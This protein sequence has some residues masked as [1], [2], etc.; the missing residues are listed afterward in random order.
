MLSIVLTI[1]LVLLN[2][3]VGDTRSGVI[4]PN[5]Q[6]IESITSSSIY[7][8]ESPAQ[9]YVPGPPLSAITLPIADDYQS[10]EFSCTFEDL[11]NITRAAMTVYSR[12]AEGELQRNFQPFFFPRRRDSF[13]TDIGGGNIT[14][15]LSSTQFH[16]IGNLDSFV[17]W[18]ICEA[19][20]DALTTVAVTD[21]AT[22]DVT[23][24]YWTM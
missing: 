2:K 23:C 1:F 17:G 19:Q 6:R 4:S 10:V 12:T 18:Y 7:S 22:V 16:P 9:L 21:N 20:D 3:A 5:Y 24:E 14:F 15:H 11:P 13:D 8:S